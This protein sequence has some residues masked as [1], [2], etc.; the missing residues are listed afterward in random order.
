MH[1][2][3]D[4]ADGGYP[5]GRLTRDPQGNLYGTAAGGG[6][7][8]YGVVFKVDALG[9]ETVL[10]SFTGGADGGGP[11]AGLVMDSSGNLYGATYEGGGAGNGEGYGV[12]YKLDRTGNETVLY[13]FASL[14][15]G[16]NPYSGV[17]LDSEGNV[18]GAT[19]WGGAVSK[20]SSGGGVV[21]R[22][23]TSGNETILHA[24]TGGSAGALVPGGL[25]RT[26]N[27]DLYGGTTRGGDGGHGVMFRLSP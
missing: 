25:L 17:V 13:T 24:F 2:F 12:V 23:D 5:M 26:S 11:Y 21:Y 8:G 6:Q 19:Y 27:G 20:G 14:S 3:T 18:Y 9:N 15:D 1:T 16:G 22:V 10:Y 7:Y 4:G